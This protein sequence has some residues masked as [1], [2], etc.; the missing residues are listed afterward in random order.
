MEDIYCKDGDCMEV[1]TYGYNSGENIFCKDHSLDDMM[2]TFKK[3]QILLLE[4]YEAKIRRIC[5]F[6][7]CN[8]ESSYNFN[9]Q[10]PAICCKK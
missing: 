4:N 10:K 3:E 6:K 7:D 9:G 2:I 8:K 1:A 5:Y